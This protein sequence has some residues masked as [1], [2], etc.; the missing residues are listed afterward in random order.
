M[1]VVAMEPNRKIGQANST[2][3]DATTSAR[4]GWYSQYSQHVIIDRQ[5]SKAAT[6]LMSNTTWAG[7][8]GV[9]GK[10]AW[11]KRS[12][13]PRPSKLSDDTQRHSSATSCCS[14]LVAHLRPTFLSSA[15]TKAATDIIS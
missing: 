7:R 13:V 1:Q 8:P 11:S 2:S 6:S 15:H 12:P 4:R 5:G 10:G 3:P 9:A 14:R